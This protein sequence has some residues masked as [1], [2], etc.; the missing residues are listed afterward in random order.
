MSK[1]D[2]EALAIWATGRGTGAS[3]KAIAR[4]LSGAKSDVSYPHDGG[5]WDR[6]E[7]LLT[8]VPGI[9][10]CFRANMA[11]ASKYWAAL[12]PRWDEIAATPADKRTDLIRSITRPVEDAD[13]RVIRLG[14]GMTAR[15]GR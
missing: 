11:S 5:D 3:S 13:P 14:D 7:R 15:W 9:R 10:E 4:Y 1:I 8:E 12:V 2:Y 6:C